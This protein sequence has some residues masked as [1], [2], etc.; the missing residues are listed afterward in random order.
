MDNILGILQTLYIGA[1]VAT[2]LFNTG[3][4]IKAVD[5]FNECLVLLNGKAL[6]TIKELTTPLVIDVYRKLVDG[7]T[8]MYDHSRAIECGKKLH[9]TLHNSG[10]KEKEGVILL[11]L[12]HIYYQT[13]KYE[14][15]KEF[16]EK[17]LSIMIETGSTRGVGI[18]YGNLGTVFQSVGQYTKAEEFLQKALVIK[19]EIGDKEG[20]AT[21][22]GNL[23]TVSFSVGQYT[24]AEE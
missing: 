12:A 16:Y 19:Q 14:E 6:E 13:S 11:K 9:V 1:V 23:G 2:F 21:D 4:I 24:K 17:A 20:E 22:Y 5:I 3:S 7:Y 18:C 10:Q 8:L 15:A